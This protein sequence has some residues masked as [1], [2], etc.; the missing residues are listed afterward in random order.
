MQKI[1]VLLDSDMQT[2][3]GLHRAEALARHTGGELYLLM[4]AYDSMIDLRF[5]SSS[6]FVQDLA[7]TQYLELRKNWLSQQTADIVA[8]GVRAECEVLW[9]PAPHEALLSRVLQLRPGLVIKDFHPRRRSTKRMRPT[10]LDLRLA[11]TCPAPLMFVRQGSPLLPQR[12]A[13]ALDVS[14]DAPLGETSLNDVIAAT[15]LQL[16][17]P[18]SAELRL[19]YAFPYQRPSNAVS[20][21]T[22]LRKL[23][24]EARMRAATALREFAERHSVPEGH[25]SWVEA[26]GEVGEALVREVQTQKIDLLVLGSAYHSAFDRLFIGSVS[27]HVLA[28]GQC[29]VL[30]IK[31]AGFVDALNKHYQLDRLQKRY[32]APD[33]LDPS[34]VAA[35]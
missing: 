18:A 23:Y 33:S 1:L 4:C 31:P 20:V 25:R 2:T 5:E 34:G 14:A 15:A 7:R 9:A 6:K 16:A 32:G 10:S 27:E 35:A 30:L 22:Y 19:V 8:R 11:R 3:A 24:D 28:H 12:V 17:A 21:S 26:R 29:D 13:A